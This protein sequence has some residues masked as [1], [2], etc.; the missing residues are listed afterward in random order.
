MTIAIEKLDTDL[1]LYNSRGHVLAELGKYD[2]A[3][4]D[5]KKVT[6]IA[7]DG[8]LKAYALNGLALALAGLGRYRQALEN[9]KRSL[10]ICPDNAWAYFNRA[11]ARERAG[12]RHRVAQDYELSLEK[13]DP[14][15]PPRKRRKAERCLKE[16]R[17]SSKS[18]RK[19]FRGEVKFQPKADRY[20]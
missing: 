15:L 1:W 8:P 18:V 7:E 14:P 10:R 2:E 11:L 4:V 6:P 5:L 13:K 12:K 20:R 3:I 17:R 19:P 9:F 16:I